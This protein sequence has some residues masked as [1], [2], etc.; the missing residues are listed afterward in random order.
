MNSRIFTLI[1]VF[2]LFCIAKAFTQ[3]THANASPSTVN[4]INMTLLAEDSTKGL[5][6]KFQTDDVY[7]ATPDAS[8]KLLIEL[9]YQ[10]QLKDTS[11][12]GI[13][14]AFK[15]KDNS[16]PSGLTHGITAPV[17]IPPVRKKRPNE[18]RPSGEPNYPFS[19]DTN[20]HLATKTYTAT[21][22]LYKYRDIDDYI[23]NGNSKEIAEYTFD[24]IVSSQNSTP[25]ASR[26]LEN[27]MLVKTYPNPSADHIIIEQMN[28]TAANT[29]LEVVIFNDKGIKVR[30]YRLTSTNN[31]PYNLNISHLQKGMYFLQLSQ[32]NKTQVKTIVK[33]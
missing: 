31:A 21:I 29:P 12:L 26:N 32:G 2:V 6:F 18:Y 4:I 10:S 23:S 9:D 5:E 20:L 3:N 8:I 1:P 19:I 33:K 25:L 22:T 17:L 30:Q 16:L 27:S 7:Y 28:T 14:Y 15:E 13:R 24:I 11:F